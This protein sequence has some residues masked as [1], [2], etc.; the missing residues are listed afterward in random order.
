MS[1]ST[2]TELRNFQNTP[3]SIKSNFQEATRD[4]NTSIEV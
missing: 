2:D 1:Q 4:V 3:L